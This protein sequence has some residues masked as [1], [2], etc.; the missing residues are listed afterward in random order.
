MKCACPSVR[1]RL[2]VS[3]TRSIGNQTIGP[4]AILTGEVVK[5]QYALAQAAGTQL[6]AG[7]VGKEGV[8]AI[9]SGV[10]LST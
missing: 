8:T 2:G 5:H 7:P 4:H 3:A 1:L 6:K 10:S 9:Q